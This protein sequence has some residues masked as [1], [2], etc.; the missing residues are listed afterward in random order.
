CAD[1]GMS[2][3]DGEQFR[4]FCRLVSA[5]YHFEFNRRFE[6]LKAAYSPFDPDSDT[7]PLVRGTADE[8]QRAL[9][10]LYRNFAWLMDRANYVHLSQEDI[11]PCLH[12]T[13]DWG[14]KV[15]VDFGAFEH[16][17]IFARGDVVQK[18]T[19]RRLR[20]GYRLEE[21]LVPTYQRLVMI[22]KLRPNR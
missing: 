16:L 6:E 8:K 10:E 4:R 5:A 3:A 9:N 2:G 14:I 7:R 21:A 13:S 19:R 22:L 12:D 11:E 18:R 1:K 15:Q 20:K 17:A